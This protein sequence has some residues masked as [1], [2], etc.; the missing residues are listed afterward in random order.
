MM[1]AMPRAKSQS[2]R[3]ITRAPF[4][5]LKK[6]KGIPNAEFLRRGKEVVIVFRDAEH[7]HSAEVLFLC[8]VEKIANLLCV[9]FGSEPDDVGH[10]FV[11]FV[12][13][14]PMKNPTK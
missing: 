6:D 1:R 7:E 4:H 3:R 14:I 12:N 2:S 13:L 8:A 5:P 10:S 11:S 9:L